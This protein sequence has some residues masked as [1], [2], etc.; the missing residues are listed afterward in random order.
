VETTR[1]AGIVW[2]EFDEHGAWQMKLANELR[3]A[4]YE[5]DLNR[6]IGS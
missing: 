4:K 6:L 1:L 3:A 5:I 2:E